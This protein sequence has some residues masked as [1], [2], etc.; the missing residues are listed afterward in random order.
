M[1]DGCDVVLVLIGRLWLT[2]A[3]ESGRPRLQAQSDVHRLAIAEALRQ[4]F[5][6]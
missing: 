2:A 4:E 6:R 3:D 5:V 1:L